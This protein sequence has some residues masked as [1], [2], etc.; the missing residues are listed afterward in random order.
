MDDERKYIRGIR[1]I[2][3][4]YYLVWCLIQ[5]N[6]ACVKREL[7]IMTGFAKPYSMVFTPRFWENW[8]DTFGLSQEELEKDK[9]RLM[10]H[11]GAVDK[12]V[13]DD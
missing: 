3:A 10:G 13:K 6:W 8:K 5:R 2:Q 7:H 9:V 1:Q 12:E 11:F 4:I